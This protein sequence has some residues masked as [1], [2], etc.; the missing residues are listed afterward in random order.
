MDPTTRSSLTATFDAKAIVKHFGGRQGLLRALYSHGYAA[1]NSETI[2]KWE[3]RGSIPGDWLAVLLD[4]SR[5]V[6]RP[7]DLHRHVVVSRQKAAA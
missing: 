5:K 3:T 1:P 6:K 4:L 2:K 7:L